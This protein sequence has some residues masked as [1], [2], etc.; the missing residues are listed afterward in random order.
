MR[1]SSLDCGFD[2]RSEDD[3]FDDRSVLQE[4]VDPR[5]VIGQHTVE[6]DGDDR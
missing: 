3:P 2:D 5:A 1:R 4:A 6:R